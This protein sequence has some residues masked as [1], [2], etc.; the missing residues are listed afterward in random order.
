M[1][2]NSTIEKKDD[3]NKDNIIF[4]EKKI[5]LVSE[6]KVTVFLQNDENTFS[7]FYNPAQVD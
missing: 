1:D 2:N 6:G 4:K 7:A 5:D 3:S